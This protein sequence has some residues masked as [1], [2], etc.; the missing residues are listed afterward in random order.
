MSRVTTPRDEPAKQ[1]GLPSAD[2][3][4]D[5]GR[6]RVLAEV[7]RAFA[8]VA[9]DYQSLLAEIAR[10][11]ANLVGDGCLVT[12]IDAD[13]DSLVSAACAHR[14]EAVE[15]D[16]KV[17][18]AGIG[19][20]KATSASVAASVIRSGESKLVPEIQPGVL[21]DQ[22]DDE[23]KHVA[24]RLNVH[25]FAVV[26]IRARQTTI[27]ALSLL[28]SGTGRSYTPADVTLLQDLAD[29]AGLAIENAR[30]YQDLERRVRQRTSELE[31]SNRELEAFS[32]SVAHDLRA[33]L[34]AIDGF[35]Q[36]LFERGADQLEENRKYLA[37]I[38]GA[39]QHMGRL[40][41][42]LLDLSRVTRADLRREEVDV[43][44]LARGV[45]AKHREADPGRQVT[46]LVEDGVVA[47][48]DARLL[49]IVL[50]N[51]LGNAWKFTGKCDD[52]RI[53][54]STRAG[55][56]PTV[57]FVRDNGAGFDPSYAAKLFG[58]FQRLHAASDFE[59]TGIGLATV[60][61]I[62][63]RHGGRVW[64]EGAIG[65]GA[66]FSFTLEADGS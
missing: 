13:G 33:P 30:L 63:R 40:I 2:L 10:A 31:A 32:Y 14:D 55:A 34:R 41:D 56:S 39:A 59:G 62:V 6:L 45:V 53:E 66:T 61:R 25:S 9:T 20:S 8:N 5:A 52:A 24:A 4:A 48:A 44:G 16:Y 38:R 26:P 7:S 46:I 51:L 21:V 17:Y 15:A 54:L 22:A 58:V 19:V 65:Q 42:G 1:Q 47:H 50:S 11:T 12:L 57:Y 23:L 29:R 49:E 60:G 37:R 18:L 36:I 28:R 64:A 35:S 3:L 43:S 27:G